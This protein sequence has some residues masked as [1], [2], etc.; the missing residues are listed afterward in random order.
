[1][2]KPMDEE[3]VDVGGP[4]DEYRYMQAQ[5]GDNLDTPFQCDLSL[6]EPDAARSRSS[7]GPLLIEDDS[8]SK[9]RCLVV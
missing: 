1:V 9:P 5:N 2:A 8:T 7:A 4:E 6:Q 3:G